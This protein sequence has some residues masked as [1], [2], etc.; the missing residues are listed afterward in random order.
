MM[1]TLETLEPGCSVD[2]QIHGLGI[3][4]GV[5]LS[6]CRQ[7]WEHV[8]GFKQAVD[9]KDTWIPNAGEEARAF[10]KSV[11]NSHREAKA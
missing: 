11:I 9:P 7:Y 6:P 3:L 10:I 5:E 8:G 2:V 4:W 1:N